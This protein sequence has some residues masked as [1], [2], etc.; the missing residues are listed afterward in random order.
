[1]R[2]EN[3]PDGGHVKV[4]WSRERS[5]DCTGDKASRQRDSKTWWRRTT[6]TLLG[7]SFGTYMRRRRH[8]LMGRR[9]YVPLRRLGD[10]P[11]R[12]RWVF[13]LRLIWDVVETYWWDV[14][15]TSPWDVVTTY[16][17]DV[18]KT[19]HWDGLTTFQWDVMGVSFETYL[20]CRW[21]IQRD[22]VTTSPQHL[23]A[24][25]ETSLFCNISSK[26][27]EHLFCWTSFFRKIFLQ[28]LFEAFT[29]VSQFGKLV[30][31]F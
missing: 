10:V 7:V 16:Q 15:I 21:D 31:A 19:Y 27:S 28:H 3:L 23:V 12:R 14:V 17:S 13:H 6:A 25:W 5:R 24:G 11:L 2:L 26:A 29:C 1:M 22:V 20:R 30:N 9:G 18:V 4:I 8:V